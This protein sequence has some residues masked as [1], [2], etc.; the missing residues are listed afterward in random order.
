MTGG[1]FGKVGWSW[2]RQGWKRTP[3]RLQGVKAVPVPAKRKTRKLRGIGPA[4]PRGERPEAAEAQNSTV[5]QV[6]A[7]SAPT[8]WA[9]AEK[10]TTGKPRVTW[11]IKSMARRARKRRAG[12][13]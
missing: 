5:E 9:N 7:I 13:T 10:L 4:D 6:E 8:A 12:Q 1:A 3:R 11:G 2:T